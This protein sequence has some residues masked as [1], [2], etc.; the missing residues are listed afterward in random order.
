MLKPVQ[1]FPQFLL[2]LQDL[3][4]STP[5][6]HPD[7]V[8]LEGALTS[9]DK[10][11]EQLDYRR[12]IQ[13]QRQ[14]FFKLAKL[15]K[16]EWQEGDNGR[17]LK[18]GPATEVLELSSKDGELV[19]LRDGILIL[20]DRGK[21][22][23][24]LNPKKQSSSKAAKESEIEGCKLKWRCDVKDIHIADFSEDSLSKKLGSRDGIQSDLA[25]LSEIEA[26]VSKLSSNL[27][28]RPL[29][30]EINSI[31]ERVEK[32][33]NLVGSSVQTT[34]TIQKNEN[35]RHEPWLKKYVRL[36]SGINA[37]E[38]IDAIRAVRIRI[39]NDRAMP[40]TPWET[41][42][43]DSPTTGADRVMPVYIGSVRPRNDQTNCDLEYSQ[44]C[45][46]ASPE[47]DGSIYVW[48]ANDDFV[49][50][51]HIKKEDDI[52]SEHNRL[53]GRGFDPFIHSIQAKTSISSIMHAYNA[54][55]IFLIDGDVMAM[56]DCSPF[57]RF[58]LTKELTDDQ[59]VQATVHGENGFLITT[60]SGIVAYAVI[61]HEDH[62]DLTL[63]LETLVL[64]QGSPVRL[65]PIGSK[66]E[67]WAWR[68]G[69]V[70]S[71]KK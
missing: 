64:D 55:W 32:S 69:K 7:R 4:K 9:L 20:T 68:S 49:E 31:K 25:T 43:D 27:E 30:Q 42:Q 26:L 3:L 61:N 41:P 39:V 67:T 14:L 65:I 2:I 28:T 37:R 36:S 53:R 54:I 34:I 1:R 6:E 56:Q 8:A 13:E 23:F 29:T 50:I 44:F 12:E 18:C 19:E 57:R 71:V 21:L 52:V 45:S 16:T 24:L 33:L 46:Y 47:Y 35:I 38:W 60:K 40:F 62:R 58:G 48:Q 66:D 10:L 11:T 17:V 63:V 59:V 70:K 22:L 15:S 5:F 51:S